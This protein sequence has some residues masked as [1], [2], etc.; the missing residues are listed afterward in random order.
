[1]AMV[2]P[3]TKVFLKHFCHVAKPVILTRAK[4]PRGSVAAHDPT[5]TAKISGYD[6]HRRAHLGLNLRVHFSGG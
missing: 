3:V 1:M 4:A 6:R 5:E 2:I